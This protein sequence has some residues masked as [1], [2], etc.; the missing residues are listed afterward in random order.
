MIISWS[1]I[2][3]ENDVGLVIKII[4]TKVRF[5]KYEFVILICLS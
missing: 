3:A 2:T 1:K 4:T 5:G